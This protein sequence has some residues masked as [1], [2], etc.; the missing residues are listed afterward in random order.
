M[1]TY[2]TKEKS[3]LLTCGLDA[4]SSLVP[5][6]ADAQKQPN[7]AEL[8]AIVSTLVK[9][10]TDHANSPTKITYPC[11]QPSDHV[12]M[13][14]CKSFYEDQDGI[15]AIEDQGGAKQMMMR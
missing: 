3:R 13:K 15:K 2:T 11:Q 12:Y 9:T 7:A 8:M 14:R 6:Q 1:Q 10:H 4:Q 5:V